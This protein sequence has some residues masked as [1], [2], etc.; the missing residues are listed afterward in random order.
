MCCHWKLA[1]QWQLPRQLFFI[2]D[3]KVIVTE[4]ASLHFLK[5]QVTNIIPHIKVTML[6][7]SLL[8]CTGF[9]SHSFGFSD[10]TRLF[11]WSQ[12]SILIVLSLKKKNIHN[13][14]VF[15][16]TWSQIPQLSS[17]YTEYSRLFGKVSFI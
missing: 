14:I 16:V 10:I 15:M 11:C 4:E 13:K 8:Y 6:Q 2:K 17:K 1:L 3:F 5:W 7:S 12:H 9:V